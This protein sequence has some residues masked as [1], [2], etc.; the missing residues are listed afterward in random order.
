MTKYQYIELINSLAFMIHESYVNPDNWDNILFVKTLFPR[1]YNPYEFGFEHLENFGPVTTVLG[2]TF[3]YRFNS[4]KI[5]N[6][7][8]V[9]GSLCQ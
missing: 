6:D 1:G 9:F 7:K 4:V 3:E 2:D 8:I 5:V